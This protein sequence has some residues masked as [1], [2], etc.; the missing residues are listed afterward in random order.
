METPVRALGVFPR[1]RT[2]GSGLRRGDDRDIRR[3]CTD[4]RLGDSPFQER[5]QFAPIG[6]IGRRYLWNLLVAQGLAVV[7]ARDF[8][9]AHAVGVLSQSER[10]PC[11]AG[12]LS[13][14]RDRFL[15]CEV[16]KRFLIT[17]PA[18]TRRLRSS[19]RCQCLRSCSDPARLA[20]LCLP[21]ILSDS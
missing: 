17:L 15:R 19:H 12:Q 6:E 13:Q 10:R 14:Q 3:P 21:A 7:V 8:A 20:I 4:S 18:D 11:A 5:Q 2:Y 1:L 9:A 16:A